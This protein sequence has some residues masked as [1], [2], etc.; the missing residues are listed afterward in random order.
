MNKKNTHFSSKI[1]KQLRFIF[2]IFSSDLQ[3]FHP[4]SDFK[5]KLFGKI[6]YFGRLSFFR[7]SAWNLRQF[8]DLL[9]WIEFYGFW[10]LGGK[11]MT[12]WLENPPPKFQPQI[13]SLSPG[14]VD[15]SEGFFKENIQTKKFPIDGALINPKDLKIPSNNSV[16]S[17]SKSSS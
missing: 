7:M 3:R 15:F 14:K 10:T 6:C 12:C 8:L 9:G 2:R 11:S 17:T 5:N 4:S 16:P 1:N 13:W